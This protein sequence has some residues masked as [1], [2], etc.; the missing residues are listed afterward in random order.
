MAMYA[1]ILA[2][3]RG[4]RLAPYTD[5]RPKP[6]VE[7]GGKP[8][9]EH[10]VEILKS[11]GVEDIIIIEGYKQEFI[12]NYFEDGSDYGVRITH[13]PQE[14]FENTSGDIK[15]AIDSMPSNETDVLIVFGDDL[16]EEG[17]E[18]ILETHRKYGRDLTV[19]L[20]QFKEEL[21]Y[22]EV[23]KGESKIVGFEE[24]PTKLANMG[25][26]VLKTSAKNKLPDEG[27]FSPVMIV[28]LM[29]EGQVTA[30]VLE[31]RWWHISDETDLKKANTEI[32]ERKLQEGHGNLG[33]RSRL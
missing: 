13:L 8:I 10:Q 27:N 17:V 28:K 25:L 12:Q 16:F 14:S 11:A 1:I 23:N 26:F 30:H 32:W 15:K 22:A 9:L 7:V 33:I 21:G 2:G 4:S 24:K 18:P 19:G 29:N 6:M 5:H 20:S 3:G 31:G